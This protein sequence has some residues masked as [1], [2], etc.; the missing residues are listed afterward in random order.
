MADKEDTF[1]TR[2]AERLS[3]RPASSPSAVGIKKRDKR[4][5]RFGKPIIDPLKDTTPLAVNK[6]TPPPISGLVSRRFLE[7]QYG[8]KGLKEEMAKAKMATEAYKNKIWP[9]QTSKLS[10]YKNPEA[11]RK[12]HEVWRK[13]YYSEEPLDKRVDDIVE[14]RRGAEA[15]KQ[16]KERRAAGSF[17]PSSSGGPYIR[18]R[19]DAS[20]DPASDRDTAE[21]EGRHYL[22]E[23]TY[24][25]G[26]KASSKSWGSVKNN[27]KLSFFPTANEPKANAQ[28]PLKN[29]HEYWQSVSQLQSR[30]YAFTKTNPKT[31][32]EGPRRMTADDLKRF[33]DPK[34]G[35]PKDDKGYRGHFKAM[36]PI[37]HNLNNSRKLIEALR[38]YNKENPKRAKKLIEGTAEIMDQFVKNQSSKDAS[39]PKRFFPEQLT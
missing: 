18:M 9:L 13:Q 11:R 5:T 12:Q 26:H 24:P 32:P 39:N 3:Q 17:K 8:K 28:Y 10:E 35:Y 29:S 21:H 23:S 4:K 1:L 15:N 38:I 19:S 25:I 30:W 34:G 7:R 31:F 20:K 37:D 14:V 22:Y 36:G 2:V 6:N 16:L 27:P 33:A